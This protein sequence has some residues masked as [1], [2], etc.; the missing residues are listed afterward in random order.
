[1]A[2]YLCHL[3]I[4]CYDEIAIWDSFLGLETLNYWSVLI[5]GAYVAGVAELVALFRGTISTALTY[6]I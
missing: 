5:I 4:C 2:I 6:K 3:H 1:M